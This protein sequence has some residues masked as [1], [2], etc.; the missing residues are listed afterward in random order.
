MSMEFT[1]FDQ[2]IG[3]YNDAEEHLLII[4][5]FIVLLFFFYSFL[6]PNHCFSIAK[7]G[8]FSIIFFYF[9]DDDDD[10]ISHITNVVSIFSILHTL[11]YDVHL[12]IVND[13]IDIL[14]YS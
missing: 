8:T 3:K 12:L 14:L 4:H 13:V 7:F 10:N 9:V 1:N 2:W 5:L 11:S 6:S